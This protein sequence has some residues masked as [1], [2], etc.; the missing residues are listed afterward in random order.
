MTNNFSNKINRLTRN[1]EGIGST[2]Q[3]T[4]PELFNPTF[5]KECSSFTSIE[6]LFE[7]SGFKVE[8]MEDFKAIP[9][10]EWERFIVKNTKYESWLDM[11]KDATTKLLSQRLMD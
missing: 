11:Q 4:F 3:L 2:T 7:K 8:S 5:L 1:L 10:E 9:D 6:D